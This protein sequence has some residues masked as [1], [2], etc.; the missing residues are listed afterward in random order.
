MAAATSLV[1]VRVPGGGYETVEIVHG[2]IPFDVREAVGFADSLRSRDFGLKSDANG[3]T[4]GFHA[5]L[6]GDWTAGDYIAP[7]AIHGALHV[8]TYSTVDSCHSS[9][10]HLIVDAGLISGPDGAAA[11]GTRLAGK[12]QF[13]LTSILEMRPLSILQE[14]ARV[15]QP[16]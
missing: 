14:Y 8:P 2:M 6:T 7:P 10:V 4:A 5:G 1:R 12:N 13:P 9:L 16:G 15:W 3:R 11:G